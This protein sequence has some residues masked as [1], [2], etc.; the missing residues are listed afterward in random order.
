MTGRKQHTS[1][2][3]AGAAAAA[4]AMPQVVQ[5]KA[6]SI[7]PFRFYSFFFNLI[8]MV[9]E[10]AASVLPVTVVPPPPPVPERISSL[11]ATV[12]PALG[13]PGPEMVRYCFFF[14]LIL[15]QKS[16]QCMKKDSFIIP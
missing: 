4:D 2:F 13:T 8:K 3:P 14:E 15:L 5:H 7:H 9:Q 1:L 12:A 10:A 16:Q 6:R 11:P